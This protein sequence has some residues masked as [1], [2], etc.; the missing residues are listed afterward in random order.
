MTTTSTTIIKQPGFIVFKKIHMLSF[1][2][3]L[4]GQTNT[5]HLHGLTV[6]FSRKSKWYANSCANPGLWSFPLHHPNPSPE[7]N[8]PEYP[9]YNAKIAAQNRLIFWTT[10]F[11][12]QIQMYGPSP[13]PLSLSLSS[14]WAT[15]TQT[16]N[17]SVIKWNFFCE[18]L[19]KQFNVAKQCLRFQELVLLQAC[20][21]LWN[22]LH[23][24]V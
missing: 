1:V 11:Q 22:I 7:G 16:Q 21:G 24:I 3:Q 9:R 5:E 10:R 4:D 20:F 14:I 17:V 19:F 12:N 8:K 6:L 18:T 13:P 23:S 15:K 2:S